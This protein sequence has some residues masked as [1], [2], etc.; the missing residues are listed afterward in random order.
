MQVNNNY[1]PYKNSPSFGSASSF[2]E[3][4]ANVSSKQF[5]KMIEF[6]SFNMSFPVM[7][8]I[9][10]GGVVVPRI[11]QA[12]DSYDK[13]EII[14]RD[15]ITIATLIMGAPALSKLFSKM[16]ENKSGFV[17]A[18]KSAEQ[19]ETNIFKKLKHYFIP[20]EGRQVYKSHEIV[21]KYSDLKQYNQG[22]LGFCDFIENGKGNLAKIFSS[23]ETTDGIMQTIAGEG[24]K[25]ADN[26]TIRE[27]LAKA[28]GDVK[29]K[30]AMD[31]LYKAF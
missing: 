11:I 22:I 31:N 12:Q 27:S 16:N 30:D 15:A 9:M 4:A 5:G 28:L 21:S 18:D 20:S 7:A 24:Y 13:G 3:K 8:A 25:N 26:K 19:G 6:D 10:A 17:L 29:F 1:T 14:R 2:I 23:S